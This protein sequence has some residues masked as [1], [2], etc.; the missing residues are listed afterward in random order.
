MEHE[1]TRVSNLPDIKMEHEY[2]RISTLE[3]NEIFSQAKSITEAEAMRDQHI[4][5]KQLKKQNEI[6]A[7]IN[8]VVSILPDI[9]TKHRTISK[10]KYI[11]VSYYMS[12]NFL[13]WMF[14]YP[15]IQS[16]SLRDKLKI[17]GFKTQLRGSYVYIVDPDRIKV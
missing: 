11:C 3:A 17:M 13:E 2:T 16:R 8:D 10:S 7:H 12:D 5:D 14:S 1:Y 15:C 9:I 4:R 6:N